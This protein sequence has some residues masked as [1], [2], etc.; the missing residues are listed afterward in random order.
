MSRPKSLLF[1]VTLL[2]IACCAVHFAPTLR[3]ADKSDAHEKI[4]IDRKLAQPEP[5]RTALLPG[6]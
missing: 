2:V 6:G 3:A 5:G 1:L 4:G